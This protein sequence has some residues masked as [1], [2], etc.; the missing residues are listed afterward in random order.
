MTPPIEEPGGRGDVEATMRLVFPAEG[1][2]AATL[3]S[4]AADVEV[5]APD[6]LRARLAAAGR[7]LAERYAVGSLSRVAG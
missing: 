1:A 4:F 3:L 6:T 7:A 5:L 2:A